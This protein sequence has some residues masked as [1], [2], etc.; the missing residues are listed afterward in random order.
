M[1][2]YG[3]NILGKNIDFMN[4]VSTST[5]SRYLAVL[6]PTLGLGNNYCTNLKKTCMLTTQKYITRI[7]YIYSLMRE[8]CKKKL[9]LRYF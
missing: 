5:N 4:S 2:S 7:N 1:L 6:Q 9:L 3:A 8:R